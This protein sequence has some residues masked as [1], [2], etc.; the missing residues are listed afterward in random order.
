MILNAI[1]VEDD[2][3]RVVAGLH[4]TTVGKPQVP[5]RQLRE[6]VDRRLERQRL[7]LADVLSE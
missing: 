4:E 3:V 6:T 7:L 1:R 5:S 2:Q